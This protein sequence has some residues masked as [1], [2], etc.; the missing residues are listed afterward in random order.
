MVLPGTPI[1][2]IVAAPEKLSP[3]L[4]QHPIRTSWLQNIPGGRETL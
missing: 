4:R 2:T 3:L 1:Y